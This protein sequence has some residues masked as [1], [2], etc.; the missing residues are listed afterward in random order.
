MRCGEARVNIKFLVASGLLKLGSNARPLLFLNKCEI[1]NNYRDQF[2]PMEGKKLKYHL[3]PD[4]KAKEVVRSLHAV[5]M[6]N[7]ENCVGLAL[8]LVFV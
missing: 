7:L 3:G 4:Y 8:F 5:S 6:P 1:T 2:L